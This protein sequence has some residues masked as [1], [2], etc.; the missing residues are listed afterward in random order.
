MNKIRQHIVFMFIGIL[1]FSS[2]SSTRQMMSR[3]NQGMGIPEKAEPYP[4]PTPRSLLIGKLTP[5]RTCY[6]VTFYDMN[7]E[8]DIEN[9]KIA[10]YVD[11]HAL[12]MDNFVKLQFDLAKNM[13]INEVNYKGKSLPYVREEDAIFV[14]FPEVKK[15]DRFNFRVTYY[16]EPMEAKRPPWDGGFVWKKDKDG[17][18]FVGVACE[19]DGAS[20]WWPNKDHPTEEPDSMAINITVPSNIMCVANGKLRETI[21][22]DV[23]TT[24]KWFV[25]NPINN[26]NVSVNIAN[27]AVINDTIHSITGIQ[28][29]QYYVL[30]YNED[31][32][33]EHFKEARDMMRSLEK[34]FGPF[35]WWE[36]GYK[37]VETPYLGMEHQTAVAYGNDF[38]TYD[39]GTRSI[40]GF[41]DYITLHE[42][43]HEWWGNNITACDGADVWLHEGFGMYSE[44]LYVEDQLGYPMSIHYLLERRKGIANRRAIVGPRDQ[45]YW[46]FE[47][48]Y[49]KGAWILHTLR[50]V[51]DDDAMFFGILSG[52]Q[53]EFASQIVCT[54]DLVEYINNVTGKDFTS[55]FNQYIFDRRPPV[56][57][58]TITKDKL[59]YRYS[60]IVADFTMPVNVLV[61][62]QEIR[63]Q[64]TTVTQELT[65]P[66][67]AT[68]QIMDW[69]YLI[70]KKENSTLKEN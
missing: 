22:T 45:Y 67:Y 62:K 47:D 40:Y 11:F 29:A 37:L 14:T 70:L 13:V 33:R 44:V 1:I 8:I 54:E 52:F 30:D 15:D 36:D 2:C 6:D 27:Y 64:P 5:P 25:S 66:D 68:V 61:N 31:V 26:Y 19:G 24:Y 32:A 50:G 16:G 34:F 65:I 9:K 69:E 10:G 18:H 58:Y 38:K 3:H 63:V 21:E 59:Y 42:T 20:L 51:I 57:E 39:S 53:D 12:A 4:E 49:N 56:L 35:P 43:A 55:F 17:R 46:G 7:I 60:G 28:P 41:I 23:K 48:A